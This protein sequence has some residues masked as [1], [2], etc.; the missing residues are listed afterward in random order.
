MIYGPGDLSEISFTKPQ[1]QI[2]SSMFISRNF[3]ALAVILRS[4]IHFD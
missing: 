4:V 1:S 2:F 3:I